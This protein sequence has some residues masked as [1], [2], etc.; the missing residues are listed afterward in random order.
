[1]AASEDVALL[2]ITKLKTERNVSHGETSGGESH[3]NKHVHLSLT[4]DAQFFGDPDQYLKSQTH[5]GIHEACADLQKKRRCYT[6]RFANCTGNNRE[7][8][9]ELACFFESNDFPRNISF[10]TASS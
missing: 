1:M 6:S 3:D 2:E 8:T 4:V 10:S 7:E 9:S 5:A